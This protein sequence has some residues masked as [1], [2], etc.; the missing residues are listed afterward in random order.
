MPKIRCQILRSK[1]ATV[2]GSPPLFVFVNVLFSRESLLSNN[3]G[4]GLDSGPGIF[5]LAGENDHT[6]SMI[7]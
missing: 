7:R 1:N 4:F 2:M 5:V 3:P 6:D